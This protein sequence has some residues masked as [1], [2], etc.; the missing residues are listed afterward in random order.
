MR[1]GSMLDVQSESDIPPNVAQLT[2][3]HVERRR[4][5]LDALRGLAIILAMGWHLNGVKTGIPIIEALLAPGRAIGWAGVDIFFVLSGFLIGGK[6]FDEQKKLGGF[7][8]RRFVIRRAFRLWPALYIFLAITFIVG[9]RGWREYIWQ[10][11]LHVAN[12]FR[13]AHATHLW[14]LAVEE[15]FYLI[16]GLAATFLTRAG[17]SL[18]GAWV[19]LLVILVSTPI[20]RSIAVALGVDAQSIQWQ[21]QYRIDALAAGVLLANLSVYH[22]RVF[23]RLQTYRILLVGTIC[24]ATTFVWFV[25]K[26]SPWGEIVGYSAA[27]SAGAALVLLVY[28][29]EFERIGTPVWQAA[30]FLGTISYSAYLWHVPLGKTVLAKLAN[31]PPLVQLAAEYGLTIS[32]AMVSTYAIEETSK[33]VRDRW[34]PSKGPHA[35]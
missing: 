25:S 18:E 27:Y 26:N 28:R 4:I 17:R 22:R 10:I 20:L 7:D 29:S 24:A 14:S 9:G 32:V 34:F 3:T 13:P 6:I 16:V 8:Y 1:I 15:Q 5:D 30:A 12:Y 11:G 23:D 21:T 33:R 2:A 19:P 31:S 35:A